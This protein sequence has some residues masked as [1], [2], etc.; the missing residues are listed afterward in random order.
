TT[1]QH[2]SPDVA[3]SAATRTVQSILEA[4]RHSQER[5][6]I[7]RY[8]F[9]K[10]AGRQRLWSGTQTNTKAR[11]LR[12][13]RL[14]EEMKRHEQFAVIGEGDKH[15]AVRINTSLN[16]ATI[17]QALMALEELAFVSIPVV[18][19]ASNT[20]EFGFVAADPRACPEEIVKRQ[21]RN[22]ANV[23]P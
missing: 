2:F 16:A 5:L 6:G 8:V 12:P 22:R 21:L 23:L 14:G 10:P 1:Q 17:H 9:S 20:F 15:V 4:H 3:M 19:E 11:K 7:V 13:R 18:Y